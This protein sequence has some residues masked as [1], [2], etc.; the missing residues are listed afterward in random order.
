MKSKQINIKKAKAVIENH[1]SRWLGKRVTVTDADVED[2]IN[3]LKRRGRDVLALD[4]LRPL[5]YALLD[6][7]IMTYEDLEEKGAK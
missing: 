2:E 4:N 1:Y 7:D 5:F 3:N 6:A